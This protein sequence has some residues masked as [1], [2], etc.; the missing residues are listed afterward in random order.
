MFLVFS[1]C[2]YVI[3][4][5]WIYSAWSE[6]YAAQDKNKRSL[7]SC[8]AMVGKP[9]PRYDVNDRPIPELESLKPPPGYVLRQQLITPETCREKWPAVVSDENKQTTFLVLIFP[10]FVY[11]IGKVLAWIGR[12]FRNEPVV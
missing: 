7:D 8:L 2:W 12:G 1:V 3:G 4:A 11:G 6:H 9:E 5:L 10:P